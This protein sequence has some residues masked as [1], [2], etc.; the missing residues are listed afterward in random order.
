MAHPIHGPSAVSALTALCLSVCLSVSLPPSPFHSL[1]PPSVL[2][3]SLSHTAARAW[4]APYVQSHVH[5]GTDGH[6]QL[7]PVVFVM[8]I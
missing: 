6:V 1:S 7:I 3:L 8:Y 2:S 5:I 4:R